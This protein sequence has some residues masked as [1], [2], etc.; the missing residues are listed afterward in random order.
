MIKVSN[1]Q[2]SQTTPVGDGTCV[3]ISK[4]ELLYRKPKKHNVSKGGGGSGT[5]SVEHMT[6]F[7]NFGF[8]HADVHV[9]ILVAKKPGVI[10]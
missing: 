1:Q 5:K 8:F 4:F 3:N 2:G 7:P 10:H 9:P 6:N